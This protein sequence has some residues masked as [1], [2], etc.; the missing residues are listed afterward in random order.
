ML[1][2]S[3]RFSSKNRIDKKLNID[4]FYKSNA[5][6]SDTI[7]KKLL[8]PLVSNIITINL[9]KKNAIITIND[10]EGNIQYY[11]SSGMFGYVG[12]HRTKKYTIIMLLKTILSKISNIYKKAVIINFKGIRK[13]QKLFVK[14]IKEK[15]LI[16]LIQYNNLIPHN[17][18]RPRKIRRI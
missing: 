4:L 6:F 13:D 8:K 14:K 9:S 16:E 17:G 7:N 12:T 15:M 1:L 3:K 2:T 11:F 5:I 10:N 18:C